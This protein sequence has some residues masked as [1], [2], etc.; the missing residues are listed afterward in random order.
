[1]LTSEKLEYF[2]SAL[3]DKKLD[4]K[5][6]VKAVQEKVTNITI[7]NSM[8]IKYGNNR[9]YEIKSIRS[10]NPSPMLD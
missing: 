8:Q 6:A 10:S 4:Y 9:E 1:M 2:T 3:N 7:G 5:D